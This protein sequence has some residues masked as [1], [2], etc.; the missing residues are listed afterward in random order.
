VQKGLPGLRNRKT[1]AALRA[2]FAAGC[3]R[4][5][6]RLVQ[7][8]VQ[9][10]HLHLLVEA[11]DRRALS[12]GVQGLLIRVAKALN[13]LWGRRGSV[14]ADRYHEHV[15]RTPR[16]VRRALC[17]VLNNAQRHGRTTFYIVGSRRV[18]GPDPYASGPWFDGWKE[19]FRMRGLGGQAPPV[20]DA[21]TWLMQVGWRRH[22]L[23]RLSEVPGP[24]VS[25]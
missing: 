3:H 6:F 23:I 8:S 22:G 15:L 25:H 24:L 21:G 14:F 20:V 16:E 11:K 10:H 12:R 4:F 1:Y 17:Y 7:Y 9:S 13:R 2:A 19:E 5:G 18:Q